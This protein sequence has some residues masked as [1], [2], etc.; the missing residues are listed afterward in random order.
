MCVNKHPLTN[1]HLGTIWEVSSRNVVLQL[2]LR[3]NNR[4]LVDQ[5]LLFIV[6]PEH[7]RHLLL[8]VAD[9]VGMDLG[10]MSSI[11]KI[12]NTLQ[13]RLN[14]SKC[15]PVKRAKNTHPDETRPLHQVVEFA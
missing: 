13:T 5:I 3:E 2:D 9:D 15:Q 7:G 12:S 8:Q 11:A 1:L 4:Q 6:L 14:C 10:F